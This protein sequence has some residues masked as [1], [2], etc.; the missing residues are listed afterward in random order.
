MLSIVET[1]LSLFAFF[2]VLYKGFKNPHF[3]VVM[4][5]NHLFVQ[6]QAPFPV[7]M[8][9]GCK[10]LRFQGYRFFD[11]ASLAQNEAQTK[12]KM[13]LYIFAHGLSSP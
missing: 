2:W 1:S 11:G 9:Q 8:R 13:H 10:R 3:A 7:A 12:A 6:N 5:K 4:I